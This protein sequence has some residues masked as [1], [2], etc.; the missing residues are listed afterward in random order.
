MIHLN[1]ISIKNTRRFGENVDI[2]FGKGATILLA[3]NGTGKTTVFEAIELALTG[4]LDRVGEPPKALIR[5]KQSGLD[6]QLEFSNNLICKVAYQLENEVLLTGDHEKLFGDKID[7]ISYL[8][9]LTHLLEQRGKDWFV[10]AD[11]SDAGSRLD[12]LSIGRELNHI[13]AKKQSISGALTKEQNRLQEKLS[14]STVEL[15]EF[16]SLVSKK[17]QLELN[18]ERIPL[19]E[20]FTRLDNANN[21]VKLNIQQN[22][23]DTADSA[24]A[25]CE[26]IKSAVN[27]ILNQNQLRGS[28]YA[29]LDILIKLYTDNLDLLASKNKEQNDYKTDLSLKDKASTDNIIPLKQALDNIRKQ[30]IDLDNLKEIR[31]KFSEKDKTAEEVSKLKIEI[32]AQEESRENVLSD[33]NKVEEVIEKTN[34]I[35]D[36]HKFIETDIDKNLNEKSKLTK[37]IEQQK[38][39]VKIAAI[40]R[41]I[42][43]NNIPKLELVKG[44]LEKSL[45]SINERL[46]NASIVRKEKETLL[47]SLRQASGEIQH[48]VST[49]ASNISPLDT[50]CPVCNANYNKGELI[51]R[52]TKALNRINP[53]ITIAVQEENSALKEENDIK[54]ELDEN[55]EALDKVNT[56]INKQISMIEQQTNLLNREIKPNFP[57]CNNET[58]ASELIS[59]IK[60]NNTL[61]EETISNR[62]ANLEQKPTEESLNEL[63]L[64]KNE[65]ERMAT[66]L[67]EKIRSSKNTLLDKEHSLSDLILKTAHKSIVKINAEISNTEELLNLT[68]IQVREFTGLKE[69]LDKEIID[70]NIRII[71][72]TEFIAKV[73]S[74][75]DGIQ[76]KW[77]GAELRNYPNQESLNV[78][79]DLL[80]NSQNNLSRIKNELEMV[81]LEIS[82]WR[83]AETFLKLIEEINSK[84][85]NESE[86]IHLNKLKNQVIRDNNLYKDFVVKHNTFTSFFNN[87]KKELDTIHDHITAI[88]PSWKK[89]LKR[90]VVDSRF[91]DGDLLSSGTFKNKPFANIRTSLHNNVIDVSRI[92][93]EAQLTDLQLTFMLAMAKKHQWT[94]WKALLLDDPTQHHDLV[95][96]SAVFDVLRD[97]IVDMDFQVM[98][99][100]HDSTQAN[101]FYRKLQNDGIDAKIYQLNATRNGVTADRIK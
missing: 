54:K 101:F 70:L 47:K 12:K 15:E 73:A 72:N 81:E 85:K 92:A 8:L 22:S 80:S 19:T 38:N 46:K 61:V 53:L 64:T 68:K 58:D 48:A 83:S 33:L 45:I 4:K 30:E 75:Q 59:M 32:N 74:Q 97:Y 57:N 43:D 91:S 5:D 7:S 21:D 40:I 24:S 90:I 29:E 27:Q 26:Q 95:H 28:Q 89:L 6:I 36:A 56:D 1:N 86:E 39:W 84:I 66:A 100:T 3:P 11:Q 52:I 63:K 51:E 62:K 99:S 37:L 94:P 25:F 16:N 65:L 96:A 14:R 88:N 98:M 79:K 13:L 44:P 77:D 71:E 31:N 41:E 35:L 55:L 60:G 49:I 23:R 67:E 2:E 10:G 50:D 87:A 82:R 76:N 18:I 34:K 20:I 9:R 42:Q 93:S 78:A 69:S 17:K